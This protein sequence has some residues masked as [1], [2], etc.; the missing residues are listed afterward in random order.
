MPLTIK[1][2]DESKTVLGMVF[3]LN[4]AFNRLAE[5]AE[6]GGP[7]GLAQFI[8]PYGNTVFNS[9]QMPTFLADLRRLLEEAH[10][11][12]DKNVLRGVE[13]LALQCRE[14][15]HLYLWFYGD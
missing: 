2:E 12:D 3:D 4:N 14:G 10:S 11:E 6:A 15:I 5:E 7:L 1:L 9:L 13:K 8:D